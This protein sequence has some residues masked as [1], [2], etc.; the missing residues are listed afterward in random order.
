M[1]A[2]ETAGRPLPWLAAAQAA[3]VRLGATQGTAIEEAAQWCAEAIAADGLVHLFGTESGYDAAG[4]RVTHGPAFH[5]LVAVSMLSMALPIAVL[6][7]IQSKRARGL[8]LY[9][10]ATCVLV[11]AVLA[12]QRKTGVVAPIAGVLTLAYFRRRDFLRMVPIA[13][14]LLVA[15]VIVAPGT[16][17][18]VIDQYERDQLKGADTVSDRVSDYDAVRPDVWAHVALGRGYGSYQP[19]GHRIIDSQIL[20]TTIDMGLLGLVAFLLLGVSVVASARPMIGAQHLAWAP[21]ALA[22]AAAA[23]C[24]L[25]L[26]PLLDTMS[27]AQVPYI[28]MTFAALVAVLVTPPD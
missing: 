24:F 12:T 21:S 7:F 13:A 18:P 27:F 3:L 25:V 20:L 28:F 6:G 19:L 17:T 4:R 16:V 15:A 10:L 22:G 1:I 23:V 5:P 8:I 11:F 26:A 2:R 14:V 9:G